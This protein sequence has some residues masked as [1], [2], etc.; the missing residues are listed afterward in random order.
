MNEGHP[1]LSVAVVSYNSREIVTSTLRSVLEATSHLQ[2][3]VL[4]VDNAST[5][6]T[7]DAARAFDHPRVRLIAL[8]RNIGYGRAINIAAQVARGQWLLM[9]NDDV[10]L[11]S[12][13]VDRLLATC[14]S[15][16][17]IGLL[18]ALMLNDDGSPTWTARSYLP[19]WRSFLVPLVSRALPGRVRNVDDMRAWSVGSRVVRTQFVV[20]ACAMMRT[21]LFRNLGGFNNVF[22]MY[23]EDLD[24]CRRL[25]EVGLSPAVDTSACARHLQGSLPDRRRQSWQQMSRIL[26]ARHTY[27]RIWS[28]QPSRSLLHLLQ[29]LASLFTRS[30][31]QQ[32]LFHLHKAV[33][34]GR[35]LPQDRWPPPLEASLEP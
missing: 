14:R 13:A 10:I 8:K 16:P 6:G 32:V 4:L 29:A 9:M 24:L 11:T 17:E 15:H 35:S 31:R 19:G 2:A 25:L 1:E 22:F 28:R 30:D 26:E 12:W 18:S 23:G 3:E 7:A 21:E 34:G 5:D 33:C 20:A 27:L